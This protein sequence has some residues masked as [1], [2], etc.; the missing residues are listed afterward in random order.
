[1]RQGIGDIGEILSDNRQLG[2]FP[3]H[4]IKRV[5]RPTNLI[6]DTVQRVDP[7]E[8]A[9]SRARRGDYGPA[10]AKEA[11]HAAT[12]DPLSNSLADIRRF[13]ASVEANETAPDIA[14]LPENSLS[15]TRHI[16]RLGYFLNADIMGICQ[17][18][19]YAVY[20]N[21][22]QG[23]PI[24]IN[25]KYAVVIVM[26]KEYKTGAASSGSDWI[27]M[28]LS[29]DLYLRLAVI[30]ETIA[31]YIRR[32]GYPASPEYTGKVNGGV[33]VMFAPLMLK[34]G[35]GEISRAGI[36]LNPFLG[37]NFKAAVILTDM[38][39]IPDMPIDFNLQDFCS[40]CKICAEFCPSS[41][42]PS[43]DKVM[44]NGYETWKLDER[45]CH[46]FRV[47]NKKGTYCGRCIKVCPW[48]RSNTM[49]HNIVRQLIQHNS[50]ARRLAIKKD[51]V[52]SRAKPNED[53]KWWFDLEDTDGI[54]GIP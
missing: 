15:L 24:D 8:N 53:E 52:F 40:H 31:N 51:Q 23:T 5:P 36:V 33:R 12:K 16:K 22:S 2:P 45:K 10:V 50:L 18:P 20:S 6:T 42:I 17:L 27:G 9:F 14:P 29:Y 13:V 1:M 7:R 30:S 11:P 26:A 32:L 49:P 43:G 44:Y 21:D 37:L 46:S 38:P 4:R 47:M 54:L 48:T 19:E 39:L 28:P 34:A 41:A 3:M 35:I 25:Y